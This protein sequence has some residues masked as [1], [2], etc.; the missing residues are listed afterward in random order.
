M[1][2]FTLNVPGAFH[3]FLSGTGAVA[4]NVYS[5]GAIER[6]AREL[7]AAYLGSREIRRGRGYSL[8]LE[9][10]SVEAVVV[11]AEY[12]DACLHSNYGG[13]MDHSEVAAARVVLERVER[14][15]DGRVRHDGWNVTL[16]GE[17]T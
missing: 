13:D 12:A 1:S 11:L 8:R 10:P 6:G 14:V 2:G 5:D 7:R 17:P 9:L 15:T 16:D 3:T 4:G